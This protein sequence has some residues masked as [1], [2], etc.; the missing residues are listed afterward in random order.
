MPNATGQTLEA[1]SHGLTSAVSGL[2]ANLPRVAFGPDGKSYARND[3]SF[4]T[5]SI[6]SILQPAPH[7]FASLGWSA[8][9]FPCGD[10][11]GA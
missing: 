3:P 5:T 10:Q 1:A 7:P 4:E 9:R 6:S 8:I 11:S 2:A